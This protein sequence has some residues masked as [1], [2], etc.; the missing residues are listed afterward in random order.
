MEKEKKKVN[1]NFKILFIGIL[2]AFGFAYIAAMSGYYESH[3]RRDT[4][5]TREAILEFER[6]IAEGRPVD[7]RDYI[8]GTVNDYRNQYSRL[9]YNVSRGIN[10]VLT[11][12]LSGVLEFFRVLFD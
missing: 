4:T 12:G 5:L 2:I 8:Q 10:S 6:D 11:D 7:I 1:R 3:V 9:G